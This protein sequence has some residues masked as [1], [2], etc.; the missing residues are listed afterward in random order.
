MDDM[1]AT[2]EAEALPYARAVQAGL[3]ELHR[4]DVMHYQHITCKLCSSLQDLEDLVDEMERTCRADSVT[5]DWM[6]G[7]TRCVV[8]AQAVLQQFPEMVHTFAS[9]ALP[10]QNATDVTGYFDI[11]RYRVN[12]MLERLKLAEQSLRAVRRLTSDEFHD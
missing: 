12:V 10:N 11:R 5:T 3:R 2:T 7:L 6:R 9:G 1:I 4:A 8:A